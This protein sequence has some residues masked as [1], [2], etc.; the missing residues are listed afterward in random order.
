MSLFADAQITASQRLANEIE[1]ANHK[2]PCFSGS[3]STGQPDTP[4]VIGVTNDV[5]ALHFVD[6]KDGGHSSK[7]S[8]SILS[9]DHLKVTKA[10]TME[11]GKSALTATSGVDLRTGGFASGTADHVPTVL[12]TACSFKDNVYS[13]QLPI[14]S[15]D[16]GLQVAALSTRSVSRASDIDDDEDFSDTSEGN[17]SRGAAYINEDNLPQDIVPLNIVPLKKMRED[18]LKLFPPTELEPEF[19][20]FWL[21]K[22]RDE[23]YRKFVIA[24]LSPAVIDERSWFLLRNHIVFHFVSSQIVLW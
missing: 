10:S 4:G 2:R 8:L 12:H 1:A 6:G 20:P 21:P 19:I 16:T 23:L 11:N 24:R 14:P 7:E 3:E 22:D 15:T 18:T 13:V 9:S 5:A 17:N